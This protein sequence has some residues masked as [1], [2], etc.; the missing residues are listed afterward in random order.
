MII[1]VLKEALA[2]ETRVAATPAT[3]AQLLKLG[4][5]VVVES[6]AG[7][8]SSFADEAYVEAGATIGEP[9]AA[10]IVFGVNAPTTD[11]ARSAMDAACRASPA[12]QR[13]PSTCCPRWPTS[14][15]TAR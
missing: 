14:P 8:L 11:H 6:G 15:A 10:D 7:E 13:S 3:V 2:G 4:Y 12:H 5:D 9:L 1:G